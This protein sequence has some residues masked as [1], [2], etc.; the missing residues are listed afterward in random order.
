MLYLVRNTY[1]EVEMIYQQDHLRCN[2]VKVV[3]KRGGD[4]D[5]EIPPWP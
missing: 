1:L 2:T 3:Q 5:L 4:D